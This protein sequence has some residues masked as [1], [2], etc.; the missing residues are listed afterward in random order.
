MS[1]TILQVDNLSKSFGDK[2]V[3]KNISFQVPK[4]EIVILIGKNGAGKSTLINCIAD[5][6]S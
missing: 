6:I 1:Q 3:L 2:Q 4:G 5:L